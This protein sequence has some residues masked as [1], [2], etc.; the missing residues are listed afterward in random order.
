MN[1]RRLAIFGSPSL[2]INL[3]LALLPFDVHLPIGPKQGVIAKR[4][5]QTS[6]AKHTH[7]LA[8]FVY[9]ALHTVQPK[10]TYTIITFVKHIYNRETPYSYL[11]SPGYVDA[12]T[13]L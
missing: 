9:G 10:T 1:Y 8:L 5:F 4:I 3:H 11:R 6:I 2:V 7:E 12:K 13:F